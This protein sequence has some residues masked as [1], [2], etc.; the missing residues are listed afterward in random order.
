MARPCTRGGR[1]D[2]IACHEAILLLVRRAVSAHQ[3]STG[4]KRDRV[5]S[6][7]WATRA[8]RPEQSVRA[9]A[10]PDRDRPHTAR[11]R[12]TSPRYCRRENGRR[13]SHAW[14][15]TA[16]SHS[17]CSSFGHPNKVHV[18]DQGLSYLNAAGFLIANV[19]IPPFWTFRS[20]SH[21]M[22]ADA[23]LLPFGLH[24]TP[25]AENAKRA[26]M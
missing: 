19:R 9:A 15:A 10:T 5:F 1:A 26:L 23:Q 17:G 13:S 18:F 11:G 22:T 6:V 2:G 3:L 7:C 24:A 16:S 25:Q 8:R 4:R 12:G 14:M 21:R 20:R